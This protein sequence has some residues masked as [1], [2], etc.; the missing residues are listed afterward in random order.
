MA[1]AATR[2]LVALLGR[3][4]PGARIAI[5]D[6]ADQVGVTEATLADDLLTLAVCGVAPFDPNALMP[7]IVEDGFV[8][9]WSALPAPLG[10]VRLTAP[11]ASALAAALQT[12]GFST[13][14]DLTSRL[15]E[16]AASASFDAVEL[17]HTIR[18]ADSD[19]DAHVYAV[20]AAA[21]AEHAV[22]RIEYVRVGATQPLARDI[23]PVSLFA[24]R[25]AWYVTAWCRHA[26][27][28]RTFRV[29]RI[30]SATPTG[31]SHHRSSQSEDASAF[32][33]AGMP[34]ATLRFAPDEPF[35]EREWPGGRV[36]ES[37][38]SGSVIAEVPYGGTAWLTRQ[39]VARLGRVEVLEPASLRSAVAQ[40]AA[41]ERAHAQ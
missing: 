12:A 14:D 28:W 29:S 40:L 16:A 18:T 26:G 35:S 19:H 39:V 37:G 36:L 34:R 7:L 21:L 9:V 15:L 27:D 4:T 25:G 11:E 17:A 31:E 2:R 22:V 5:A 1:D 8:E 24:E 32:H 6:L 30:R 33:R 13:D 10:T 23:E 41:D 20:I 3:L 38:E